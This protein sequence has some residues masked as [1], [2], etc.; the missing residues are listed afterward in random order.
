[1]SLYYESHVTIDPLDA[2]TRAEVESHCKAHGFRLAKLYMEKNKP[3]TTDAFMT[4][5]SQTYA[6]I[7][8]RT[9]RFVRSLWS[10]GITIRRYKIELTLDDSKIKDNLGLLT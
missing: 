9:A 1:M 6:D 7:R 8:D 5:R 2:A 4:T 3:H 10:V